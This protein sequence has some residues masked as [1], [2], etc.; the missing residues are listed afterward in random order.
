MLT[1]GAVNAASQPDTQCTSVHTPTVSPPERLV[2]ATDYLVL[3]DD[4]Y[5]RDACALA[6]ADY[7][8]ASAAL[9]DL[10]RA[11][12]L[13]P[14]YSN[15]LMNRG[16]IYNYYYD[17]DRAR[18]IADYD[19]VIALGQKPHTSVCG[20]RLLA[21]FNGW[22]A[23]VVLNIITRGVDGDCDIGRSVLTGS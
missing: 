11:I 16:D 3:G 6:I 20:H 12:A 7:T 19:R 17:I 18:A 9:S 8:R 23:G 5:D 1:L 21:Y 10:D 14:D 2:S 15:A 22:N 13:H 4:D